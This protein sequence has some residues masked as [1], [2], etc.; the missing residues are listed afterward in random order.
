MPCSFQTLRTVYSLIEQRLKVTIRLLAN[1]S[2]STLRTLTRCIEVG[3][4]E[5]DG[6]I[7]RKITGEDLLRIGRIVLVTIIYPGVTQ[8]SAAV[9]GPA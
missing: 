4:N 3:F 5:I 1:Q 9:N 8:D 6:H 2:T 7:M